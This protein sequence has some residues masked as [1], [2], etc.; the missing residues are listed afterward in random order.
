MLRI[1]NLRKV[2]IN[3]RKK[4][5]SPWNYT[6]FNTLRRKITILKVEKFFCEKN[7]QAVP[8]TDGI[9]PQSDI[10]PMQK[11]VEH[12]PDDT[13]MSGYLA[14][15]FAARAR[16]MGA[17]S[18][19]LPLSISPAIVHHESAENFHKFRH[20][21]SKWLPVQRSDIVDNRHVAR[22][23]IQY[24]IRTAGLSPLPTSL[25]PA[26]PPVPSAATS[27]CRCPLVTP[28]DISPL[29]LQHCPSHC[30]ESFRRTGI[31]GWTTWLPYEL[32]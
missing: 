9:I 7:A 19:S 22:G 1:L 11:R 17:L 3:I 8:Y 5:N 32:K 15:V 10:T 26:I 2:I 21:A 16:P 24:R 14:H 31:A 4:L 30:P 25:P 13:R 29:P 12:V 6:N 20:R 23:R 18:L 27:M 28:A